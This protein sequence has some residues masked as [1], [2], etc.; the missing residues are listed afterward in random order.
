[1]LLTHY[2]LELYGAE[3]AL[4][5]RGTDIYQIYIISWKLE[6]IAKQSNLEEFSGVHEFQ[7]KSE[8]YYDVFSKFNIVCLFIFY[9]NL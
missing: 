1:M 7:G 9:H 6:D 4:K 3:N 2:C 8:D 5:G